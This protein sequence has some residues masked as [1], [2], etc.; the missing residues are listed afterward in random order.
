MEIIVRGSSL[1]D[2]SG[3]RI[4]FPKD[5]NAYFDQAARRVFKNPS[6]KKQW[7]DKN[8]AIS[9]G[10]SDAQWKKYVKQAEE[11]HKDNER[12]RK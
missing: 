11:E 3:E 8:N 1:R 10:S 4:Y 2:K 5:G 9:D 7:M 12:S 6:E